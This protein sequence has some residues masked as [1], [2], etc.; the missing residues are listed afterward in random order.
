MIKVA[1]FPAAD[2]YG[3]HVFPLYTR[4]DRLFE[5]VAAPSLRPD[6]LRYIEALRPSRDSQ[7]VLMNA[8]AAGEYFGSNINGDYFTEEC[9]IHKPDNWTG[10]PTID[11]ALARNW[12]YGF[13]TFYNARPFAHHRNKDAGR[14]FGEVELA[15]WHPDMKRVEL[16]VRV[17]RDKCEQ[18]GG[19][20][21]WDKLKAGQ[22]PDVSM[23]CKVPFDTCFPAG[24]LVRTETGNKPIEQ[25]VVGEKVLADG[26]LYL[27]VTAVMRR[28]ADDLMQIVASGLPEITPTS[29]HPFLIVRR[30]EVRACKGTAN[31]RRCRH[32]PDKSNTMLC[33][34]CGAELRFSMTWTAASEVRPG[35]YMVVP[36]QTPSSRVDIALPRARML[37][38]YLGDGYIIKQRTGKKKDGEY[39]DMGVGFS[40]GS[41]EQEHLRRLLGTLA[42]A[43]L[44]NEPGVYDAGCERKAHIVSVYDQEAAVW[45]QEMGGRG[46]YGKR[47]AEDVFDWPLEA[48]LE[49]VGGYIDTDGSFDDKG[50][51]RIA[52]VNRGLLLDVQRLLLQ[53]RIT[54]TVCFAGTSSGYEGGSDCWYLVLSATQAQ[55]FLGR[56]VKVEPRELVW[57]SPQSFFWEGYW[58]TPVKSVEELDVEREVYNLSVDKLEQYV[59]EGRVVHNCS[60]CLD[61]KLYREAAATFDPNR[62][63]HPGEAILQFHKKLVASGKPGIRGLAITRVDYCEHARRMMNRILPDGRKV[64][65]FN[66]YPRFFDISFVFIGADKTAKVMVKIAEEQSRKFWFMPSVELAEHLG[67]T[68]LHAEPTEEKTA[69]VDDLLKEAF[70]GKAA[71]L[72]GAEIT[73]DVIPSQLAGQAV[74]LLSSVEED[75]PRELVNR[76]GRM[77]MGDALGTVTSMGMVLRPREFQRM[78]MSNIGL[79]READDLEDRGVIFPKV[80]TGDG[81]PLDRGQMGFSPLLAR[82]LEPFLGGRSAFGPFIQ[83][84]ITVIVV[85]PESDKRP[86]SHNSPLLRKIGAAY[87]AY[88]KTAMQYL[89]EAVAQLD[90]R[91]SPDALQKLASVS[92][93]DVITPTTFAYFREAFS[94]EVA[95]KTAQATVG[96]RGEGSSLQRTRVL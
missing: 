9:L 84:R 60:I 86:T 11:R 57:E 28:Q 35:D 73:K 62:H 88:R 83:R 85:R 2:Q 19:L 40:V 22:F 51:V 49:L 78:L 27:P 67:Y 79:G 20:G 90:Q 23:G 18:F 33:R 44:Q 77:P 26:G 55:R 93:D 36:A 42:E 38:Y 54:A 64:F 89:P 95:S 32:T 91:G 4:A 56:S 8:M 68:D 58:L 34:R 41:S 72:K 5:K 69:S 25:V 43:G 75:L 37:G 65:V 46:S 87:D 92:V 29:N 15:S 76:M 63:K 61:W 71:K 17:D 81:G 14:A 50:Q 66:D 16:V 24:T 82:L 70:L 30:E 47:L 94:S 21:A 12:Q 52:S 80:D 10:D 7:Y 59:A 6:V 39:R 1:F 53:E 31:G 74:P 13:P 96:Q 3:Q 45:L 48:K